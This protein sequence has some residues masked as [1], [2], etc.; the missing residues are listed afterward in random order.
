M[1]ELMTRSDPLRSAFRVYLKAGALD[2]WV[3]AHR[4]VW[5][6]LLRVQG[7]CGFHWM[8]IYAED[9]TSLVVVSEVT[10]DGAWDRLIETD[11]H[12]RWVESLAHLSESS[13]PD[14]TV[15]RETLPEVLSLSWPAAAGADGDTAPVQL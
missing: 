1:G 13:L 8:T 10:D 4:A 15:A 3:A 5:P 9:E 11:V 12:K 7:E 14:S 6:D 2:E